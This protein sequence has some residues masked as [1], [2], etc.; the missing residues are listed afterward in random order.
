[1]NLFKCTNTNEIGIKEFSHK[2]TS[3][4]YSSSIRYSINTIQIHPCITAEEE[5]KKNKTSNILIALNE[6]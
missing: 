4:F 2:Y 5:T 3:R 1:M 6:V